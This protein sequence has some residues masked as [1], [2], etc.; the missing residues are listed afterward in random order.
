MIHSAFFKASKESVMKDR[1]LGQL[2]LLCIILTC[3]FTILPFVYLDYVSRDFT[4]LSI[5]TVAILGL[6]VLFVRIYRTGETKLHGRVLIFFMIPVVLSMVCLKGSAV[7]YW[8]YP[9]IIATFYLL[10]S[11]TATVLNTVIALVALAFTYTELSDYS[12]FRVFSSLTL[13]N[14]FSLLFSKYV[15]EQKKNLLSTNKFSSLRNEILELTLS[16]T[17]LSVILSKIARSIEKELPGSLCSILLVDEFGKKLT[18]GAAPSLPGFYNSAIDGVLIG[19]GVGSC[20]HAAFTKKRTIIE[21]VSTHPYW[22]EFVNLT[23]KAGLKA[24]WSEPIINSNGLVLATFAIYKKKV[25]KPSISEL[26]LIEQFGNL[27]KIAVERKKNYETIW[28][29]A[30][31][32]SLTGLPNRDMFYSRVER[33]VDR[34][35]SSS[36]DNKKSFSLA[37]FDLD[38]FKN[39]NDVCGND[40]G[41]AVLKESS[42]RIKSSLQEGDC[43][44]RLVGDVF[45]IIMTQKKT[46]FQINDMNNEILRKLAEPVLYGIELIHTTGSIGIASTSKNTQSAKSLLRNLYQALYRAKGNGR[47][48]LCFFDELMLNDYLKRQEMIL[49]LHQAIKNEE[50]FVCYQPIVD[51]S[52]NMINKAEALIRWK[53]PTKGTIPPLDFIPLAEETGLIVEIS[54]W[55]FNEVIDRIGSWSKVFQNTIQIK[56]NTSPLLYL[57]NGALLK[58]WVSKIHEAGISP[59]AIGIEITENLLMKNITEVSSV[60]DYLRMENVEV[61]IDDFGTGYSSFSYLKEFKIDYI[62]ID[63]SFVQDISE[64]SNDESLCEA[65]IAMAH[66]LGILVIA[67][68]IETLDQLKSLT[69]FGCDYGQGYYFHKPLPQEEFERL[70]LPRVTEKAV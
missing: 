28:R 57:N 13:T 19:K 45:V 48:Q 69:E 49:D 40:A 26:L 51:T 31:F 54:K 30:N 62:K 63:K 50:F 66:K 68:G 46:I 64:T 7:I 70:L 34:Y 58:E 20:G 18:M 9:L 21:N 60:I 8:L 25:S 44:Y 12:L 29:Q 24:C 59:K 35:V 55:V 38:N 6:S 52:T 32:D 16:T 42:I 3:I 4:Q 65:I 22:S 17:E 41:D 14:M 5:T 39:I 37:I 47:N 67:E 36:Y 56:I 33:K 10:P 11:I 2:F 53:H 1:R 43:L 15:E 23:T 61:S 27:A